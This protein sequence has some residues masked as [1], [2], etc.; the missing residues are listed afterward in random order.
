MTA[1]MEANSGN[2]DIMYVRFCER[3]GRA[4][5]GGDGDMGHKGHGKVVVKVIRKAEQWLGVLA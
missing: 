2:D 4:V 1:I 3:R 5:H